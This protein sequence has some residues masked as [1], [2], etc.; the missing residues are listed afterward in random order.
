MLDACRWVDST[1]KIYLAAPPNENLH[2]PNVLLVAYI[3]FDPRVV[4]HLVE[5]EP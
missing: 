3:S 1:P 4:L 2:K 5:G